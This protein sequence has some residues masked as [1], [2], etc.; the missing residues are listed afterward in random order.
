MR[1]IYRRAS[2]TVAQPM[3]NTRD[4]YKADV[5]RAMRRVPRHKF[6][7]INYAMYADAD[8]PLPIGY[9][10]TIS[11]PMLVG[12]MTELLDLRPGDKVLEIG[13]GSGYQT[14]ILAELGYVEVY[15]VEIIPE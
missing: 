8:A 10:Q 2:P 7:P 14:A 1:P 5:R 12:V 6:I 13:T 11:Q 15:S 4:G 3:H 9:G